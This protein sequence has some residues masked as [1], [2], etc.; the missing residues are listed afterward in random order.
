MKQLSVGDIVFILDKT[1]HAVLPC[2]LVEII[3]SITVEGEK[4]RHVV[5]TPGAKK[6]FKLEEQTTPWFSTHEEARRYL[7]E[8]ATQLIDGTL[9]K[10]IQVALSSFGV[11]VQK[12]NCKSEVQDPALTE[13]VSDDTTPDQNNSDAAILTNNE[14]LYV[15]M[16]GQKVKV[17][18]PKEL[19]NE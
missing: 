5:M 11:D 1:T 8:A 2:Q 13:L 18:L 12:N 19:T 10:A 9:K 15:E 3:S 14:S 7:L 4:T 17:T 16:G 6:K